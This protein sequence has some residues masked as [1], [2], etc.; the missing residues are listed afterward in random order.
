MSIWLTSCHTL[1][2]PLYTANVYILI[3]TLI[4]ITSFILFVP[5][6]DES[7][8]LLSSANFAICV[9]GVFSVVVFRVFSIIC[10]S[11]VLATLCTPY[12][13]IGYT[14]ACAAPGYALAKKTE[15]PRW[16]DI[17][18]FMSIIDII[19]LVNITFISLMIKLPRTSGWKWPSVNVGVPM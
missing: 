15:G 18:Y 10:V 5:L 4:C 11:G 3:T 1:S 6:P 16:T 17:S 8:K 9:I 2:N 7:S 13:P 14:T 12:V 19:D